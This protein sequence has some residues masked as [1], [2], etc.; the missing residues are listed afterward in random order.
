MASS[1]KK[2]SKTAKSNTKAKSSAKTKTKPKAK[3]NTKPKTKPT[4]PNRK[5]APFIDDYSLCNYRG[6]SNPNLAKK[7]NWAHPDDRWECDF[8]AERARQ[9][10]NGV[11]VYTRKMFRDNERRQWWQFWK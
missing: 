4:P 10:D 6:E 9:N 5:G 11:K 1:Y 2:V 3:S 8:R 7:Y